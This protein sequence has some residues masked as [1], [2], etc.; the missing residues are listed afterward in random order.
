MRRWVFVRQAEPQISGRVRGNQIILRVHPLV[1]DV[2][3]PE[4]RGTIAPD[5]RGGTRV[6]GVL[7][8]SAGYRFFAVPAVILFAAGSVAIVA[9][10]VAAG[11]S[12][13]HPFF[14]LAIG[15]FVCVGAAMQL[16]PA[17]QPDELDRNGDAI[18]AWL[19]STIGDTA[20]PIREEAGRGEPEDARN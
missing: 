12:I 4:F 18:V 11:D 10:R 3:N 17:L 6:T 16:V 7:Q 19:Q 13:L 20:H 5:E 15:I 2:R 1:T 9:T 8:T 14:F